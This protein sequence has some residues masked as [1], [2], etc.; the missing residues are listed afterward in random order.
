[1]QTHIELHHGDNTATKNERQVENVR[2][3]ETFIC[4]ECKF[5]AST[6]NDLEKH[7]EQHEH[8][9]G[10]NYGKCDLLNT[11]LKGKELFLTEVQENYE[12][13]KK[14]YIEKEQA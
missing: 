11:E 9:T 13:A 1:M 8:K 6:Q 2:E 10:S 7:L 3:T 14:M 12:I 5:C 4:K